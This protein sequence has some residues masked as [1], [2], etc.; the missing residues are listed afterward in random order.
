MEILKG[1]SS[2]L[3]STPRFGHAPDFTRPSRIKFEGAIY[4]V[5]NRGG[6]RNGCGEIALLEKHP[7]AVAG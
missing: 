7:L 5:M 2:L 6:S 1:Q 4:H 3:T